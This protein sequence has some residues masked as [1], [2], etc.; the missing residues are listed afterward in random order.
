MPWGTVEWIME[1][2]HGRLTAREGPRVTPL[3][4]LLTGCRITKI[5]MYLCVK[6][7]WG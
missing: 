4:T 5:L 7:G 1:V 3:T 6:L 2:Q